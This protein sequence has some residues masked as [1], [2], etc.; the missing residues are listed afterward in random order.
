MANLSNLNDD[1]KYRKQLPSDFYRST[2]IPPT[3]TLNTTLNPNQINLTQ[4]DS[5]KKFFMTQSVTVNLP[6]A[7][8]AGA[9]W[10]AEFIVKTAP[11]DA[12]GYYISSSDTANIFGTVMDSAAG[13]MDTTTGT[14]VDT[15]TFVNSEASTG[16]RV[17]LLCD[18]TN[19][20][21]QGAVSGAAAL[22]LL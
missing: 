6:A 1:L 5:G 13:A 22:T 2:F 21:V 19:F 8:T 16:D 10:N 20:H 4:D 3:E 12:P 14:G 18:G 15:I 11:I 17:S 9:G 7:A